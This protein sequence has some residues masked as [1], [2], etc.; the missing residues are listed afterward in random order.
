MKISI[1]S[2]FPNAFSFLNESINKRAVEK[3]ALELNVVNLLDFGVGK[4]KKI[5]DKPFGGGAGMVIGIEPVYNSLKSIGIEPL[6]DKRS[7]IKD[8]RQK[9]VMTS[10]QGMTWNQSAAEKYSKEIDEL[11][12]ICGHYEGIDNRV[13]DYIVDERISVGNYILSGGELPAMIITDS[14]VRLLPGVLGNEESIKDETQFFEDHKLAE[15]P[16][17]TR[18]EVFSADG[19]DLSVPEILLSGN[20]GAVDKWREEKRSVIKN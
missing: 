4:W 19:V 16:V 15:Y 11:V 20:H 2:A 18:P 12:I 7:K 6:K 10:A 1:I 13:S 17:Y 14:I 3:G 9:I 8:L 5:D